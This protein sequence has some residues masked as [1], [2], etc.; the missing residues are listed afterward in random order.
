MRSPH[1]RH[2]KRRK[3]ESHLRWRY[4]RGTPRGVTPPFVLIYSP[5]LFS[6][7]RGPL[8]GEAQQIVHAGFVMQ[9]QLNQHIR[10]DIPLSGFIFGITRLG[11]MKK[12]RQLCLRQPFIF[13]QVT[14]SRIHFYH[15]K[16]SY[17]IHFRLL[18]FN[19]YWIKICRR[20]D[21]IGFY[22]RSFRGNIKQQRGFR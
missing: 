4:E 8:I 3:G 13:P 9:S 19:P 5:I 7:I 1:K 10:R 18:I 22:P 14:N 16:E 2:K 20:G 12:L 6:G 11:H 15:P 21:K 17:L